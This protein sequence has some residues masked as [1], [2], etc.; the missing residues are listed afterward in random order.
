[1]VDVPTSVADA[2][3]VIDFLTKFNATYKLFYDNYNALMALGSYIQTK[4]PE[5]L[6]EYMALLQRGADHAYTLEQLKATRD[7]ATAWLQ[8]VQQGAVGTFNWLRSQVGLGDGG[9]GFVPVIIGVVGIAA[10]TTA[11]VAMSYWITDAYKA[12]QRLNALQAQEA[13]G[14]TPEQAARVVNSVLGPPGSGEFLGIPWTLLLWGGM[15]IFLGPPLIR[16]L[17]HSKE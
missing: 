10:A 7:S 13:K 2:P 6:P 9:L 11:L 12:A 8:W 17:T 15:A 4:H 16:M 1:M 3:S 14:L 5:L